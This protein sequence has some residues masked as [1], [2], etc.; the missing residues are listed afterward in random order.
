MKFSNVFD[1]RGRFVKLEVD[2]TEPSGQ[3][4]TNT[5][6]Y[7]FSRQERILYGLTM[8]LDSSEFVEFLNED[9]D[10]HRE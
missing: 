1:D 4:N 8:G 5:F 6:S 9:K 2:P 7:L 3:E 10:T